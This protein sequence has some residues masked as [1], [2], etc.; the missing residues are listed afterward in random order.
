M[1]VYVCVCVCVFVCVCVC[2][3]VCVRVHILCLY[4]YVFV[5]VCMCVTEGK[6]GK[7]AAFIEYVR[8]YSYIET[9]K[10]NNTSIGIHFSSLT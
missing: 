7:Q 8:P 6:K 3:C 9:G 1:H 5:Y 10:Y 4:V 2:V